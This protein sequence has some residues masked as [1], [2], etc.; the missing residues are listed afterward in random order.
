VGIFYEH[1]LRPALHRL[2]PERSHRLTLAFLRF[3]QRLPL[4]YGFSRRLY[5]VDEPRLA[6]TWKG[7]AFPNP[8]GLAA[9]ADKNADAPRMFEAIGL[10]FVEIGTV[11]PLAQPGNPKPRVFRLK[12]E[13]SLVNCLGFPSKGAM[14]V[15]ASLSRYVKRRV[16]LGINIGK[17]AST[18][19]ERAAADYE[20]CLESLYAHGDYFTV[21]VSSPNTAGLTSLQSAKALSE[22]AARLLA[23][24]GRVAQ[25]RSH[26]PL[27][28]KL[29]PDMTQEQVADAVQACADGGIDGIIATNTTTDK[30]LWPPQAQKWEGGL[31]GRL[32]HRRSLEVV[33]AV[34]KH[35]P[36]DY[37]IIGAGGI[38]SGEDARAMLDAGANAVQLY[39]GMVYRGPGIVKEIVRTLARTR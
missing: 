5:A 25:G 31:S 28:V 2:D 23:V 12:D 39:T 10:G 21:N 30:S 35:A 3:I 19:L 18:P 32:L 27:L 8:V 26:K 24:R 7:L 37:F 6:F 36:K 20:N 4:S 11:T 38:F 22:L 34:R 33:A 15:S 14:A 1:M 16:P 29:S 13:Q 17:N 9:G